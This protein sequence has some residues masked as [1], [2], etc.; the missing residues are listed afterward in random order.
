MIDTVL[1]IIR[2]VAVFLRLA[3]PKA[4]PKVTP[5]KKS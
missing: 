1:S 3:R 4:G 5:V 2:S